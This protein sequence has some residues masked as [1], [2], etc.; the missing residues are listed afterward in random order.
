MEKE[1]LDFWRAKDM[2]EAREK[3]V[4]VPDWTESNTAVLPCLL[5]DEVLSVLPAKGIALEIG[6]G[7]GRLIP[8]MEKTFKRVYGIDISPDMV[9]LSE[10]H[11]G[12]KGAV[13]LT[14]GHDFPFDDAS[15]DFVYSVIAFQHIPYRAMIRRY[16]QESFR[17]LRTNG[18]IRVQTHKGEGPNKFCNWHGY[19][20]SSLKMFACEFADA[21]FTVLR[22]DEGLFHPEYLWV[23]AQKVL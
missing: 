9:R 22:T 20:Y 14:D 16:L 10:D 4:A 1:Y 13:V 18:V 12:R 11:L 23:T 6:A 3:I 21:G 15:V 2:A 8:P 5:T 7:V 17:V 19:F